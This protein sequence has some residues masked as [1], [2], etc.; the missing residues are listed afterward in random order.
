MVNFAKANSTEDAR[1]KFVV[2]V[3]QENYNNYANGQPIYPK[4]T[5]QQFQLYS[6]NNAIAAYKEMNDD[7]IVDKNS[8]EYI[9]TKIQMNEENIQERTSFY[10]SEKVYNVNNVGDAVDN[11]DE[12]IKLLVTGT[13]E[14][15]KPVYYHS[16]IQGDTAPVNSLISA[17]EMFFQILADNDKTANLEDP[18]RFIMHKITGK[19]YGVTDFKKAL[20]SLQNF[21]TGDILYDYIRIWENDDLYRYYAGIS[22]TSQYVKNN[23][24]L[25]EMCPDDDGGS[26]YLI[27]YGVV[28]VYADGTPHPENIET[29]NQLN[30]DITQDLILKKYNKEGVEFRELTPK[31][32]ERAFEI[33]V[34]KFKK[35]VEREV[36]DLNL[37]EDQINA[38]TIIMYQC[39]NIDGFRDAYHLYKE[40]KIEEFKSTFKN[41]K[42]F[43]YGLEASG[44]S[45]STER[46]E[47]IWRV[48]SEGYYARESEGLILD[49]K[50][51]RKPKGN[52]KL[53]AVIDY[54]MSNLGKTGGDMGV[55]FAWCAWYVK[56]CFAHEGYDASM[57]FDGD[58]VSTQ[59]ALNYASQG[60][61]KKRGE[62]YI[63]QCGDIILYGAEGNLQHTGMVVESNGSTVHTIEGNTSRRHSGR[64]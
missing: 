3:L 10:I 47:S 5:Q 29:L 63:P 58:R 16:A 50:I 6:L 31:Q 37:S 33:I 19:D 56:H 13:E 25:T 44:S 57:L 45:Y 60:K 48:F 14:Q 32:L 26:V 35:Q 55:S 46:A 38:L 9:P 28:L 42:A 36:K 43:K 18:M 1:K 39:G 2:G 24:Y 7:W 20:F 41:G 49:K 51:Y 52:G 8:Y 40:G 23:R 61:F 22:P 30:K 54:A 21:G 4:T 53:S 12:F 34:D 17:S 15:K 64:T 59:S 62:G 11:T 27:T